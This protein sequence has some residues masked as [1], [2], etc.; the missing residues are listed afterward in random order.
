MKDANFKIL[1]IVSSIFSIFCFF[2]W[3]LTPF[4]ILLSLI[5]FIY[6]VFVAKNPLGWGWLLVIF[7]WAMSYNLYMY[8]EIENKENK[9]ELI[10]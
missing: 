5:T 1:S 6:G 10:N 3:Q 8:N 7:I 2:L 4:L 9:I